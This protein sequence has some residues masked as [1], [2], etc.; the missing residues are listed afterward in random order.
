MFW[1]LVSVIC[2]GTACMS[3]TDIDFQSK[4]DCEVKAARLVLAAN[5]KGYSFKPHC[6][7]SEDAYRMYPPKTSRSK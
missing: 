3:T 1:I 6:I 5:D 7:P 2:Q 4:R